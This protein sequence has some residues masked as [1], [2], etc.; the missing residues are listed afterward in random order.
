MKLANPQ[1]YLPVKLFAVGALPK[2]NGTVE[3]AVRNYLETF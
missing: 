3:E 1:E 2:F